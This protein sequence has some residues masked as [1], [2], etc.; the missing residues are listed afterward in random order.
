MFLGVHKI[1]I[2]RPQERKYNMPYYEEICR[3]GKTIEIAK[4][5]SYRYRCKGEKR[6]KKKKLTSEAQEKINQRQAVKKLRRLMNHNFCDNDYLITLDYR[7]EE[8]PEDSRK[9]QRD[10]TDFLKRLRKV[11]R[12]NNAILK[13]IYVKE[14]GKRGAAHIHIMI[15]DCSGEN[16]SKIIKACWVRGRNHVNILDTD[17]QYGKIAEYFVKYSIRTEETE[18]ELIGKRYYPSRSLEKPIVKKRIIRRVNTFREQIK[19]IEGYYLEKESVLS[20]ITEEGYHFF[21]YILH[22]I[23]T[24]KR[25]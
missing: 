7:P 5:H 25:E 19:N 16:I 24:I 11:Y 8:R 22:K 10:I 1:I 13:Y 14:R 4:Y 9:M 6:N 2:F 3:A 12:K 15:N 23:S 20:G 18:G 17:G 21:S